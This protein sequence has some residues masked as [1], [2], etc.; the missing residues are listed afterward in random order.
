M[1]KVKFLLC[2]VFCVFACPMI[3]NAEC[4]YERQA[5]LSR[6]ASNVQFS[7]TYEADAEAA[8]NFTIQAANITDDIYVVDYLYQTRSQG[9][10][11]SF[12]Y[13]AG[14]SSVRFDIYSNDN[15]CYGER[16]LTSYIDL[17]VYNSFSTL[18]DCNGYPNFKYCQTWLNTSS[19]TQEQ[20]DDAFY[21]YIVDNKVEK[22]NEKVQQN[23][24]EKFVRENSII[25]IAIVG[26]IVASLLFVLGKKIVRRRR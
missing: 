20:F 9:Q 17:P 8:P 3:S 25:I 10:E 5:E 6:I 14:G 21:N 22:T 4:S 26:L 1:K 15:E 13:G 2:F 7:Y 11:S 12:S 19:L 24:F 23:D 16:I 18:E